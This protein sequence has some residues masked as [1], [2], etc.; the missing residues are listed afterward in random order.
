MRLKYLAVLAVLAVPPA[1]LLAQ[2]PPPERP[3][4]TLRDQA[5]TQRN[6]VLR[7]SLARM[8]AAG[9]EGAV[10]THPIGTHGHGAK[11]L[12]GLWDYQHGVPGRCGVR[13]SYIWYADRAV[14][15]SVRTET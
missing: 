10:Y 12:I 6:E 15:D 5:D 3:F 14:T 13:L 11:P 4:G 1:A 7:S 2:S 8:R 9:I